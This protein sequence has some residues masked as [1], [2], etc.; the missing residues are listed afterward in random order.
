METKYVLSAI[1][2]IASH[3]FRFLPS[4]RYNHKTGEWAH[5]TR[6]T[7]FP[8]RKWLGR[9]DVLQNTFS[10]ATTNKV[11]L[12][13]I[14]KDV[15]DAANKELASLHQSRVKAPATD[16]LGTWEHL[17]WFV[18]GSEVH[19]KSEGDLLGPIQPSNIMSIALTINDGAAQT[20]TLSSAYISKQDKKFS[21]NTGG[22]RTLPQYMKS[23]GAKSE[24]STQETRSALSKSVRAPLSTPATI[25]LVESVQNEPDK[26][27]ATAA[28]VDVDATKGPQVDC[29]DGFVCFRSREMFP[30]SLKDTKSMQFSLR[31]NL[32]AWL[33][34]VCR[35]GV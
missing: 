27:I 24:V 14:S 4:Y 33:G 10:S 5:S 21:V 26:E 32:C 3:G 13:S 22:G 25:P 11:D 28:G 29:Q 19:A 16:T 23:F 2:F 17:R 12:A 20:E 9:F 34:S 6:L 18:L 15:F 31:K 7:K 30:T 8:E 35:T 1:E